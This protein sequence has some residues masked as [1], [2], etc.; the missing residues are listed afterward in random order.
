MTDRPFKLVIAGGGTGGHVQPAVAT[1]SVL[2]DHGPLDALWIGSRDGFE[3]TAA[4]EQGIPFRAIAA[5]KL[6]RYLSLSTAADAVR[7]PTGVIQALALLRRFRPEAVFA[8]GGFVSVPTAVAARM[9]RIPCLSHEQT[10]T[11]GLATRINARFCDVV[12]LAYASSA[13]QLQGVRARLVVTG[14]PIRAALRCGDA[15]AGRTLFGFSPASP[16]VYVT[17]GVLG[18][19]AVNEAVQAALPALVAVAQ[20][21]HQCGPAEGNGDYPRLL[22]ACRRLPSPLQARY[23]VRERIGPELADVFAAVS[24]VVGRAG[25]G[26]VAELATLGKPSILIPL[27]GA[28]GDEQTQNARVLAD[29]GAAVLLPQRELTPERLVDA[30]RG[31]LDDPELLQ[32]M[33]ERARERGHGDAAERLAGE[34]LAVARRD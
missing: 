23:A 27:P 14:N 17:G 22:A 28:G 1:L 33:S 10:A 13:A 5:G 18:A 11:A 34:I 8:T 24:L 32:L 26:T 30:V 12:A 7:V 21:L 19:H 20:I 4:A 9:L 25:A 31:L 15:V 3:R 16:V 2:R 29:A 6:R